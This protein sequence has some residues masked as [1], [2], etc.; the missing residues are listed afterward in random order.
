MNTIHATAPLRWAP[1]F[2]ANDESCFSQQRN[3]HGGK[4]RSWAQ[5]DR[6][7]AARFLAWVNAGPPV[8]VQPKRERT[9]PGDHF[10]F[11]GCVKTNEPL[12]EYT[13]LASERK[14]AYSPVLESHIQR[15]ISVDM[16]QSIG[17]QL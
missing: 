17:F 12:G 5:R 7:D 4:L 15:R 13:F 10:L 16:R 3:G 1:F 11:A 2:L 6:D 8:R 14:R 9:N